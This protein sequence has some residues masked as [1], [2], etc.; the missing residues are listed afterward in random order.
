MYYILLCTQ[1]HRKRAAR[2][3]CRINGP[4]KQ[5]TLH[6]KDGYHDANKPVSSRRLMLLA[7]LGPYTI[8]KIQKFCPKIG[9]LFDNSLDNAIW[10]FVLLIYFDELFWF[11]LASFGCKSLWSCLI[12][13]QWFHMSFFGWKWLKLEQTLWCT[14]IR[15]L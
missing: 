6:S 10:W 4:R 2:F 15:F 8:A 14:L 12:L 1:T 3:F 7:V 5:C 13:N 9:Q 11:F